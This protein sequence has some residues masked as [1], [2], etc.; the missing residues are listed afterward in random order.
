MRSILLFLDTQS[1]QL[2][3]DEESLEDDH[4][5]E[6]KAA[7]V[8]IT[9]MFQAPLEAKCINVT[10]SLDKIEDIVEYARTYLRI[11]CDSYKKIWYKL[12]SSPDSV[13]WPNIFLITELLYSL[14]FS[15]VKVERFFSILK[16][17]K[18]ERRTSLNCS[19]L[20]DLL[21]VNVK[22]P[23]LSNFS[24]DSVVNIWWSNCQSGR[25]VNQKP[26]K[27]YR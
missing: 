25:R 5:S 20:N 2:Q 9:D 12:K 13:K 19:T 3:I 27:E 8:S 23:T 21:E 24:P 1:W 10:L 16:I 26:R 6:V 4:L 14:P 17:I 11:G 7:L 15:T 18:N 22:G